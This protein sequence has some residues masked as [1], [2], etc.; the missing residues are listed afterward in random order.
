M[1]QRWPQSTMIRWVSLAH[2]GLPLIV[3]IILMTDAV[4]A[5]YICDQVRSEASLLNSDGRQIGL[6]HGKVDCIAFT[7]DGSSITTATSHPRI[8]LLE[9][10]DS[11]CFPHDSSHSRMTSWA[12]ETGELIREFEGEKDLITTRVVDPESQSRIKEVRTFEGQRE[13]ITSI[14][15]STDGTTLLSG[16]QAETSSFGRGFGQLKTWDVR[17]GKVKVTLDRVKGQFEHARFSQDDRIVLSVAYRSRVESADPRSL[18]SELSQ[19]QIQIVTSDA[20]TGAARLRSGWALGP[21]GFGGIRLIF[22][23]SAQIVAAVSGKEIRLC[24]VNT[25]QEPRLL[26]GC[27]E[28]LSHAAFSSDGNRIAA[29]SY[30]GPIYVWDLSSESNSPIEINTEGDPV[31]GVA[32]S[33]EGRTIVACGR[34]C[35]RFWNAST[36][37]PMLDEGGHVLT[38]PRVE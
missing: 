32:F 23:P 34:R 26:S 36:G 30:E 6:V 1:R 8:S 31:S 19:D 22:S 17:N 5:Q 10:E 21:H 9:G 27:S 38:I 24:A 25:A 15:Y 11:F 33:P 3:S 29:N 16:G 12:V 37:S 4:F 20:E 2:T 14:A 35:L 7:P 18:E 13:V 28:S